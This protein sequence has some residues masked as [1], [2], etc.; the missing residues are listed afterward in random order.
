MSTGTPGALS[1]TAYPSAT[2]VYRLIVWRGMGSLDNVPVE[3]HH[4]ILWTKTVP[5]I[6]Y[7]SVWPDLKFVL[8]VLGIMIPRNL[9][10][11]CKSGT[12]KRWEP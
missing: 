4:G 9:V 6:A 5:G 11:H 1:T 10:V 7:R 2:N 8:H 3:N 12:K